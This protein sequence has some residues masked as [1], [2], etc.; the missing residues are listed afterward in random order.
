MLE[1]RTGL[2][3]QAGGL[4]VGD[5]FDLTEAEAQN[6]SGNQLHTGRYRFIQLDSTATAANVGIGKIGLMKTLALGLNFITSYDKG[7]GGGLRPAVFINNPTAGQISAA[8]YM[9]IQE[10][11]VATVTY[12]ASLTNVAPAVGDMIVSSASGLAD[13]LTQSG[14]I[15]VAQVGLLIGSALQL[16]T[17]GGTGQILL[18]L[19]I[20]Q[21]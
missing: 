19:E 3:Y 11:G 10:Q 12:K 9:F 21:S 5:Y 18:D 2:P 4:K 6:L 17:G 13:D 16:P 20:F 14:N 7:L 15:T 8:A 1:I